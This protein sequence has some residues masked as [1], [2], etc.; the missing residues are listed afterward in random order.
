M[1]KEKGAKR[2][3]DDVF[4]K[5]I[6]LRDSDVH[7]LITC[8][9]CKEKIRREDSNCCHYADRQ[10]MA[11]RWDEENCHAGCIKC[12]CFNKG[13]HIHEYG[14]FLDFT[15]GPGTAERLIQK[16][17]TTVHIS[18]EQ[19]EGMVRIYKLKIKEYEKN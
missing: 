18:S 2:K 3:L 8:V 14:K 13:F 16:S 19:M 9:S 4:S 1:I 5:F 6:R 10:H 12:N 15:Y 11:T 17:K 7:G